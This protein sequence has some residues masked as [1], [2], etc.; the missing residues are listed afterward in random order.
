MGKDQKIE[1]LLVDRFDRLESKVDK[2]LEEKIPSIE[3]D[4]AVAKQQAGLIST[5]ITL[6]GGG[7]AVAFTWLKK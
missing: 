6:V 5:A 7:L 4:I 3:K 2:I 1:K